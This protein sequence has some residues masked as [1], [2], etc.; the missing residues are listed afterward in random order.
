M[1]I[2]SVKTVIFR[3]GSSEY[4]LNIR[5]VSS[6]ERMQRI[7]FVPNMPKHVIGILDLRG[8]VI[9][10]ID[11]RM[12]FQVE[13]KMEDSELPLII[14]VHVEDKMIGL[15][16][17]DATDI[18]DIPADTIQPIHFINPF[19]MG[20]VKLDDRLVVLVDTQNI[21]RNI[22]ELDK[23]KQLNDNHLVPM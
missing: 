5:Q 21:L 9:P 14:V 16:V 4:G 3:A 20:V 8:I 17:D 23:I 22:T 1:S 7:Q 19:L 2:E 13:D 12:I 6:I 15:V 11:L 10:V 18:L